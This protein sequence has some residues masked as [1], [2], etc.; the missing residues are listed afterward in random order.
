MFNIILLPIII[1]CNEPQNVETAI[2]LTRDEITD[3]LD[4]AAESL[5]SMIAM[6]EKMS[7]DLEIMNRNQDAIFKAVTKC[8]SDE[9]CDA[10]KGS[11]SQ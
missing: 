7:A 3:S 4:K 6:A 8:I 1:G 11:M 10:L 9:T 5:D 2:P